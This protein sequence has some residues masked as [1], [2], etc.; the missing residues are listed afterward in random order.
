MAAFKITKPSWKQNI[1]NHTYSAK[2]SNWFL[3]LDECTELWTKVAGN[4][5]SNI[6]LLFVSAPGMRSKNCLVHILE[7]SHYLARNILILFISWKLSISFHL[8]VSHI[9]SEEGL[10]WFVQ[11][12]KCRLQYTQKKRTTLVVRNS[13]VVHPEWISW[14][15]SRIQNYF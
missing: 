7:S 5:S 2:S 9:R 6:Y 3:I 11:I 1:R 14:L 12:W 13:F 15:C 10:V 4:L 8:L